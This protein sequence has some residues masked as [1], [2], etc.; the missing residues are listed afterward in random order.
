MC[1]ALHLR[2][3]S[4]SGAA[5]LTGKQA[6]PGDG[7]AVR[8]DTHLGHE[9]DILLRE[10]DGERERCRTNGAHQEEP[11]DEHHQCNVQHEQDQPRPGLTPTIDKRVLALTAQ[12]GAHSDIPYSDLQCLNAFQ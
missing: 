10:R 6:R 11:A 2:P 5:S 4:L 7:E 1:I 8:R 3:C 12:C 9:G